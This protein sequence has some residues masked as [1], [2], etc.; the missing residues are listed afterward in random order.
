MALGAFW[1]RLVFSG[2]WFG[3]PS[4]GRGLACVLV[5]WFESRRGHQVSPVSSGGWV[6]VCCWVPK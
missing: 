4:A 5:D 1:K 3:E 2:W 6:G